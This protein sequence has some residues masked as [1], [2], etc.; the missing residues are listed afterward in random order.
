MLRHEMQVRRIGLDQFGL[1]NIPKGAPLS[2]LELKFLPLYLH[3][4]YQLT[5]AIK[6]IGGVYYT[7]AV[8]EP[9]GANP[10]RVAEPVPAAKQREA[11]AAI[12]DTLNPKEL[13]IP[14]NL[15]RL[16]PPTADGY[17]SGRSELFPKR[18]SPVFDPIGAAE[19]AADLAV[20]GL[21]EP[22]RAARSINQNARDK[23]VPHFREVV[24][25]LV[26]ATWNSPVPA[27]AN[28]AAIQRAV[29]SL[30]VNKLMDLAANANAQSQVRAV[31]TYALHQ[32]AA[33]L[34]RAPGIGDAGAHRRFTVDEIERF[35]A[36]P[37][38]PRK[39]TQPLQTP[40]GDP[41]GN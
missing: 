8:R 2:E 24:D 19:I 33:S 27:N 14:E 39:P 18:T 26:K 9:V 1:R 32:L 21:L 40:P 38:E 20:S 30:V 31:A 22:N 4:R 35:L 28:E 29:Q 41:I 13:T 16:I 23:T 25:A 37:A 6:N 12:L 7:Y 5:G 10:E 34:K 11:L 36:R 17:G 15:L 3:H